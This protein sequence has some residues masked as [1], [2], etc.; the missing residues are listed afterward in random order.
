MNMDQIDIDDPTYLI[1]ENKGLEDLVASIRSIGLLNPPFLFKK[2][3][4]YSVVS[5]FRR[6]KAVKAM[7]S[8]SVVSRVLSE[9]LSKRDCLKIAITE[10]A[11][12]RPLDL[13]E[14]AR[15]CRLLLCGFDDEK[16][17]TRAADAFGLPA[18][19]KEIK[20][21]GSVC[22]LDRQIRTS[23]VRGFISLPVA[24]E[25]GA[26]EKK[27]ALAFE[28]LFRQIKTGINNQREILNLVREICLRDGMDVA[29]FVGCNEIT[30]I[31][32]NSD[33]DPPQKTGKVRVFLREKRY[34]FMEKVQKRFDTSL[35][36]LKLGKGIRVN[37]SPFFEKGDYTITLS[38]RDKNDLVEKVKQVD[39]IVQNPD[40]FNSSI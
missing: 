12:Q 23:L 24:F 13:I 7:G 6:I 19:L 34:P 39:K 18:N 14:M 8:E 20:K 2:E 3:E 40:I 33:I 15:A 10:N 29:D 4:K 28:D 38:V 32:K 30:S 25:L 5:G 35:K 11:S 21:I 26:M 9:D 37:P 22:M 36:Q 27:A 16:Q 31:L 17:V 1:T